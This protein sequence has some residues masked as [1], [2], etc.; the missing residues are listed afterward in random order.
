MADQTPVDEYHGQG[1]A[2]VIVDGKRVREEDATRPAP[3][4]SPEPATPHEPAAP[5]PRKRTTKE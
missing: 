3:P 5:A 4:P 2:F 1:G